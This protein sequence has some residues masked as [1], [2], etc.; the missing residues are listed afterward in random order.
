MYVTEGQGTV[1]YP[2]EHARGD[3]VTSG[4]VIDE[5][6]EQG[7]VKVKQWLKSHCSSSETS[8]SRVNGADNVFQADDRCVP[9]RR[10]S[11]TRKTVKRTEFPGNWKLIPKSI[12]QFPSRF[13]VNNCHKTNCERC[14]PRLRPENIDNKT[15]REDA[16]DHKAPVELRLQS[17]VENTKRSG[18]RSHSSD[19]AIGG[20]GDRL[21]NERRGQLSLLPVVK[22][23]AEILQELIQPDDSAS[24][25]PTVEPEPDPDYSM[26]E[27]MPRRT[28]SFMTEL[29][30]VLREFEGNLNR[31]ELPTNCAPRFGS[32]PIETYVTLGEI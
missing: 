3:N 15:N 11:L 32:R 18:G 26:G 28:R 13:A 7:L 24:A 8:G 6:E 5:L 17:L 14:D 12:E 31:Y 10:D 16:V 25:C 23:E 20:S 21:W 29:S 1:F 19:S 9:F 27:T 4:D 2:A 22:S 30:S